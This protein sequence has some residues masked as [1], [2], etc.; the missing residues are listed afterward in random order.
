MWKS[1]KGLSSGALPYRAR[2]QN[3]AWGEQPSIPDHRFRW[4]GNDPAEIG[5]ARVDENVSFPARHVRGHNKCRCSQLANPRVAKVS[6][7]V[8]IRTIPTCGQTAL[9]KWLDGNGPRNGDLDRDMGARHPSDARM[10]QT[11]QHRA[12]VGTAGVDDTQAR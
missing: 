9:V 3:S 11:F 8:Q 2:R 10:G 7:H 5:M 4:A 1:S 12:R 6:G